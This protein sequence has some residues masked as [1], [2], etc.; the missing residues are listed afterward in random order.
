MTLEETILSLTTKTI[1][2]GG[3]WIGSNYIL[4]RYGMDW[5]EWVFRG[6]SFYDPGD[7]AENLLWSSEPHSRLVRY[8]T[9]RVP[10]QRRV[11]RV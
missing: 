2:G 10:D 6:R 9:G 1:S 3:F 11:T 8:F 4:V 7:L 5:W